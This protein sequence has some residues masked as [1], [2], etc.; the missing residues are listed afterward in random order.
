MRETDIAVLPTY[1]ETYNLVLRE[2]LVR[3]TPSIVTDTYGSEII[4]QGVNGF[5]FPTGD[6]SALL[7]IL[8]WLI[9]HPEQLYSLSE[10]AK[11]TAGSYSGG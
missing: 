6:A 3:G 2:L 7:S 4:E 9:D 11:R 1:F 8:Q 10:G 5:V